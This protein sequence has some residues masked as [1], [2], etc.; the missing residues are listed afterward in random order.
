MDAGQPDVTGFFTT[1]FS[2]A[3]L[4]ELEAV[5]PFPFR[6]HSHDDDGLHILTVEDIFSYFLRTGD[7]RNGPGLYMEFKHPQFHAAQV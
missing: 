5:Q 1:D 2:V 7:P 3:E 6:D 4:E